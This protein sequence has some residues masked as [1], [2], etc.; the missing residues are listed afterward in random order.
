MDWSGF[1]THGEDKSAAFEALGP[2]LPVERGYV[3]RDWKWLGI[4]TRDDVDIV[5]L[6]G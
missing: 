6:P 2:S 5:Q 4:M 3:R 1:D